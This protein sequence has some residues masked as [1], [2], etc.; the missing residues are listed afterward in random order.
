MFNNLKQLKEA[1]D[2]LGITSGILA[3]RLLRIINTNLS[4]EEIK[5][6]VE[7]FEGTVSIKSR[8]QKKAI[9]IR[10]LQRSGGVT[11]DQARQQGIL[12]LAAWVH[13]LKKEGYRIVG[14][15][16]PSPDHRKK[17]YFM[18]PQPIA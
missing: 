14:E 2:T 10:M 8:E 16:M 17:V 6:L 5:A 3:G 13:A 7:D 18:Y 15:R 1:A 4:A 12:H 11:V 9:V